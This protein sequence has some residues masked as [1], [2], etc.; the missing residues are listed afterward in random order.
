MSNSYLPDHFRR[1]LHLTVPLIL[2]LPRH[3]QSCC[4]LGASDPARA[5]LL[6]VE[7]FNQNFPDFSPVGAAP[8]WRVL[9]IQDGAVTTIR[10]P[11]RA[12]IIQISRTVRPPAA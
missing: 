6:L 12:I 7:S 1:M 5:E 2:N 8:G 3:R 10:L 9:A 4:L 11:R